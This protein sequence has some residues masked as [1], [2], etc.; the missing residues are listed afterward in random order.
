[1]ADERPIDV[2]TGGAG[3]YASLNAAETAEDGNITLASGSDEFVVFT[4]R[5]SDD[6]ADT[7]AVPFSG[8]TTATDNYIDVKGGASDRAR[9][10][11]YDVTKYR[12]EVADTQIINIQTNHLRFDGIQL[13]LTITANNVGYCI[14][15]EGTAADNDLRVGDC[16]LNAVSM[17][18]T[19]AGIGM[20]FNEG[21]I[22]LLVYNTIAT[23]FISGGDTSFRGMWADNCNTADFIN[24]LCYNCYTGFDSDAG[25]VTHTNCVSFNNGGGGDFD[26]AASTIDFCASDDNDGTNNVAGNETDATWSTDFADAGNGD[27][28]LLTG[29]PLKDSGTNDPSGSGFGDPDMNGDARVGTWDVGPDE[30]VAGGTAFFASLSDTVGI[31][32][33]I[34]TQVGAIRIIADTAG[35]TDT[36]I[37]GVRAVRSIADNVGISDTITKI[38]TYIRTLADNLS[39]TDT[40]NT[41]RNLKKSMADN[42]G[43]TDVITGSVFKLVS[44]ADTIGITDVLSHVGTF[45]RNIPDTIGITDAITTIKTAARS[46]ADTVGITDVITSEKFVLVSL[47]DTIGITDTLSIIGTYIR[48]IIDGV[49]ITD[50]LAKIGTYKRSIT[51]TAGITD[52]ITTKKGVFRSIADTVGITDVISAIVGKVASLADTIGITDVIT[53]IK[54]TVVG[55]RVFISAI[56]RSLRISGSTKSLTISGE[57]KSLKISGSGD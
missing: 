48:S 55:G 50:V 22:I 33:D 9:S 49:G 20:R 1:M 39:I 8:W 38:G 31:T 16:Y 44:L 25:T 56:A 11:G 15:C 37:T 5:S 45:I 46:I 42:V 19:G 57:D 13:G 40:I 51:D 2:D 14:L 47:A 54:T 18:G 53:F 28:T 12:L 32:D 52:T 21:D 7:T 35:I 36:I 17:A 24:S 6:S 30:V 23:G 3:D 4:C 27:F 43:I 10:S 41:S 26:G 29:S 34:N